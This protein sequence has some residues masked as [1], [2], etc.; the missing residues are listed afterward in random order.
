[1]TQATLRA[2]PLTSTDRISWSE[3]ARAA[4]QV[5]APVARGV[6]SSQTQRTEVF[7]L[8]VLFSFAVDVLRQNAQPAES[9]ALP[10]VTQICDAQLLLVRLI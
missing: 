7:H 6:S 10:F 3:L 8:V 9:F 1:M 5:E 4:T 2:I